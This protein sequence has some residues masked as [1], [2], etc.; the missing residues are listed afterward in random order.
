MSSLLA[1]IFLADLLEQLKDGHR[2]EPKLLGKSITSIIWADDLRLVLTSLK[3]S[4]LQ[5]CITNLSHY[6]RKWGL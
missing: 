6:S 3:H 2:Y 5:Q 1:N 4:G